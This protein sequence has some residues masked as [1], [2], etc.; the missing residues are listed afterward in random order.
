MTRRFD[1]DR[2]AY[3]KTVGAA[4]ATAGVAGCLGDV[5]GGG[6]EDVIV[7]GTA[8]GFAPFEFINEDDELVGFDIDLAEETIDRAGYEVGDWTDT[9]FDSLIPSLTEGNID[10]I[11]A[12]MTINEERQEAIAFSDPYYESDQA[13]L[14]AAG[15]DVDASAVEDLEGLIV[16]AQGG[17]T[18][19]DEAEALVE[20]GILEEDD[21]R[22]YD[23]YPLAVEDLENGNVDAIII[24]I[25][26]A[27]NF[28]SG[29]DVEV[30]FEIETG[31]VF[32]FG[33]RQ[34]DDRLGDINDAL[35]EIR[36]DGTY[37][38]LIETWF[39]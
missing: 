18:G 25:P 10:F 4:G 24:D 28:A 7:P 3:L 21:L 33:M 17:T 31:E 23:N 19:L 30:A 38:D 12:G 11:A 35:G 6:D 14:V 22:Q 34:D 37:E 8:S 13:V 39:E 1:M 16:G 2:R 9:E 27:Q 29:R 15:S 26:V 20:E 32:G 5:L 36:D